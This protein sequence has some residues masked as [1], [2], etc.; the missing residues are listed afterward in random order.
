MSSLASSVLYT[1]PRFFFFRSVSVADAS[2]IQCGDGHPKSFESYGNPRYWPCIVITFNFER[3]EF[4][5]ELFGHQ[6]DDVSQPLRKSNIV[7][8]NTIL[9]SYPDNFTKN[10]LN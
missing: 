8:W 2:S 3:A 5:I 10:Y 4:N 6:P 7:D 9:S 1:V